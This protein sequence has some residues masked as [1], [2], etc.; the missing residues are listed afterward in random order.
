M[1]EDQINMINHSFPLWQSQMLE[2]RLSYIYKK[3][4]FFVIVCETR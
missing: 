1:T 2:T 4:K 3:A